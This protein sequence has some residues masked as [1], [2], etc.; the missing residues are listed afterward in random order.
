MAM[1]GKNG[2]HVPRLVI[3]QH[4]CPNGLTFAK[5]RSLHM[6]RDAIGALALVI[7]F[8]ALFAAPY[9]IGVK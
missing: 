3:G 6:I 9:L 2:Q 1:F 5:A 8:Y 7:I 4:V